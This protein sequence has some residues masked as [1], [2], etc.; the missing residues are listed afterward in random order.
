[1]NKPLDDILVLDFT[2]LLSGP[3]ASLRLNDLGARVIKVEH[4]DGGD[5]SRRLY[6]SHLHIGDESAFYQAINRG[7]ESLCANLKEAE[8]L[9]LIYKLVERADIVVHNFRPGVMERLGLDYPSLKNINPQIIYGEISGYG[10]EGPWRH[11]PGQ[12]LLLQAVSGLVWLSG[13]DADGPV[14]M[15]IAIADLLAGAQ[16]AQGL[17][18]ALVG[19][20]SSKVEVSMLEAILDFQFEPLTLYFQ[21]RESPQRGDVCP[22]HSL[23]AAPYGLYKTRDGYLALAM[24]AIPLLGELLNCQELLQFGDAKQWFVQRDEI[25]AI[26]AT[27]IATQSTAHWLS[28]LE[29]ADVWCAEVFDWQQMLQHDGFKAIDML[30]TVVR[31]DGQHYV[32]TRCPIRID[33]QILRSPMGAPSLGQHTNLVRSEYLLAHG[34]PSQ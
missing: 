6:A 17:L 8:D 21:D 15:G 9:A 31:D 30:Q 12:D 33:E 34:E 19:G 4:K 27:H 10:N 18:A 20:E 26:L 32:T 2:Q 28:K 1:M 3:S 16:L 24:C 7:K 5:L 29:P 13:T 23:V 25:K 14:P 22:A 11:K